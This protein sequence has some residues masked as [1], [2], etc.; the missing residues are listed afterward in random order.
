M[1]PLE[2]LPV[3][4]GRRRFITIGAAAAV[5]PA[6]GP[7][8]AYAAPRLHRWKGIALGAGAEIHLLHADPDA[9]AA[10]FRRV[11]GEISRLETVF[12]LYQTGSELTRLNRDGRLT[13][14][15][16]DL[17]TLL[18]LSSRLHGMTGGAFDPTI[19]SL[20]A[21]YAQAYSAGRKPRAAEI[22]TALEKTGFRHVH[23]EPSE[24]RF[25]RSGMALTLNGIA[26]GYITDR[27]SALLKAEGYRDVVVDLGEISAQGIGPEKT[28][29]GGAGWPVTLRPDASRPEASVDIHL[30][31]MAVASSARTG[32]TVDAEGRVSHILDP[33]TGD[34]VD[35][36]MAAVSVIAPSAA[37]A[38][39][40]STAAIVSS[41]KALAPIIADLPATRA[42]VVRRDRTFGWMS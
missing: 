30:T 25:T 24:I 18:G 9:V 21:L 14:P 22:S 11:E 41:E 16:L 32:T 6:F 12:S 35:G 29:S 4:I 2:E 19:Q 28:Q 7:V 5:L 17:V 34:P 26:Q 23:F 38:D 36:D 13:G 15:S 33:R 31:D 40:L 10:T 3:S 39:G 8:G 1:N 27:V 20:W 37:I 42:F